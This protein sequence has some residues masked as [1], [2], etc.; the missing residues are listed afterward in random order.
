VVT[1]IGVYLVNYS[2]KK[3]AKIILEPEV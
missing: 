1:L 2:I 3:S